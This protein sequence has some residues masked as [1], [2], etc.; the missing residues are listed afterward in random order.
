MPKLV[1]WYA[2]RVGDSDCY[3]VV[4]RTKKDALLQMEQQGASNYER[5]V[6]KTLEYKDA[7]DLFDWVT[8]EAGGRGCGSTAT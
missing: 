8:S 7:F 3:S 6:K 1:Y 2:E 4:A 5:P